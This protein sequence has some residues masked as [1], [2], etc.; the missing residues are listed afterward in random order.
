[1]F[2]CYKILFSVVY[3]LYISI[4]GESTTLV[5]EIRATTTSTADFITGLF[6]ALL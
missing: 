5:Y 6:I 2:T 4:T 1:M 3:S